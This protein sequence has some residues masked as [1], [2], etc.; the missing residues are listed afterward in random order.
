MRCLRIL[1]RDMVEAIQRS[2]IYVFEKGA[3]IEW[4]SVI[5]RRSFRL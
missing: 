1:L 3:S 5:Y 2:K 4:F